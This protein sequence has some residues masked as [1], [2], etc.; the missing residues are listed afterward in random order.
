[1]SKKVLILSTK[2]SCRSII[3]EAILNK[4]LIGIQA[5]SAGI[6][7]S[8]KVNPDAKKILTREGLWDEGYKSKSFSTLSEMEFDL[9]VIV[10]DNA[11]DRCPD[12]GSDTKVIHI[13]YED[14]EGKKF[15]AIEQLLKEIKME[16]IPITRIELTE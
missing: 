13:G 11:M 10:C 1:M 12:F 14:P 8:G 6:K 15:S 9:V 16:L 4:H 5:Y 3:A 2:N 7:A